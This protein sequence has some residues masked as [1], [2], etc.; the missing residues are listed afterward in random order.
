MNDASSDIRRHYGKAAPAARILQA[1]AE[2]GHDLERLSPEA[3]Y[4][5]DQLH[6]RQIAATRDH[7][8][9]LGLEPCQ[10][11]LDV[12]SGLGGP[13]RYAA[14][15]F[16]VEVTGIDLTPELVASAIELTACVG[17]AD[18]VRFLQGDALALP[19]PAESFDRA[20]SLYVGMNIADKPGVLAEIRRVLKRGGKLVWSEVVR[21]SSEAPD[22]PLPWASD[23]VASFLVTEAVL[24]SALD[25]AHFRVLERI[26]ETRLLLDHIEARRAAPPEAKPLSNAVVFT[27]GFAERARNFERGLAEGRLGSVLFVTERA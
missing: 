24:E 5:V 7:L 14:H 11:L 20:S 4:V 22:F 25:G 16:G 6:G 3:L 21:T 2:S 12:G 17:L 10:H 8:G 18:R 13:A 9:K 19:F 23:S 27:E 15:T 26:D 1:L